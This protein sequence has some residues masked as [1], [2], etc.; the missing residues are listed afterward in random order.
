ML[1]DERMRWNPNAPEP[2]RADGESVLMNHTLQ[3]DNTIYCR[4][5][6]QRGCCDYLNIKKERLL[7]HIR[8]DHLNFLPFVCGGGCGS[9][10]WYVVRCPR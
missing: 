4:V 5:P 7:H 6:T 1:C 2:L 9:Q 10:F 8:K 3:R